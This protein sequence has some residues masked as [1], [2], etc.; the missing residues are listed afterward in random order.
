MMSPN[1]AYEKEEGDSSLYN[2]KKN[3]EKLKWKLYSGFYV[4]FVS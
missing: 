1:D 2:S 3:G 4:L